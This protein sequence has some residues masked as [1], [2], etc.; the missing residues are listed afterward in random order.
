MQAGDTEALSV[1]EIKHGLQKVA[2]TLSF[3]HS[4]CKRVHCNVS[5][6]SIMLAAD[7]TWKLASLGLCQTV[8]AGSCSA[9]STGLLPGSQCSNLGLQLCFSDTCATGKCMH[10]HSEC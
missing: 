7:G 2:E 6:Q 10:A 8:S 5:P 1:L 9:T 4:S 3:V